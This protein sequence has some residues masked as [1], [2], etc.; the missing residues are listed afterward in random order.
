M[1]N[2]NVQK[3][4]I[5]IEVHKYEIWYVPRCII[6]T[7]EN[8]VKNTVSTYKTFRGGKDLRLCINGKLNP[9]R[10]HVGPRPTRFLLRLFARCRSLSDAFPHVV[11][12]LANR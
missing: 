3:H 1:E 4:L 6:H 11:Q 5:F 10:S 9:F 2:K 7:P 12:T 8:R